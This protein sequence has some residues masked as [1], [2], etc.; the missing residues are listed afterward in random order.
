[1]IMMDDDDDDDDD[2]R[3]MFQLDTGPSMRAEDDESTENAMNVKRK[4]S[5]ETKKRS[6][7]SMVTNGLTVP[8][9]T[10]VQSGKCCSWSTYLLQSSRT[11]STA[12]QSGLAE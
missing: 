6:T 3:S 10:A 2:D 4:L 7:S 5:K 9:G 11:V 8:A 1:M 12:V